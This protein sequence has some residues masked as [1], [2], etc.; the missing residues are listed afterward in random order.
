MKLVGG[1]PCLD[2]VNTVGGRVRS[3]SGPADRWTVRDD[4][5]GGYPDLLAFARHSGLLSEAGGR[6][7]TGAAR[8]R[9]TDAKR[10]FLRAVRLREALHLV[11]IALLEARP[12]RAQDLAVVNGELAAVR[13]RE[14]L[15]P[16]PT[17][18]RWEVPS[19]D[20]SLDSVLEPVCRA[21]AALLAS[22][23]ILRLRR[24]SG[25]DCGWLFLDRS[26][27]R[28]RQWCAMEDCGNLTKVRRFRKRRRYGTR[29]I[30]EDGQPRPRE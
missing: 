5:L 2:F 8:R 25:E 15:V 27:N 29:T 23:A 26:R 21:A 30:H 11:L 24:C 28:S 19:A 10:V 14:R 3:R 18:L 6:D 16:A 1:D 9:P 7:L 20:A 4:K 12:P 13:A 17:G 22:P